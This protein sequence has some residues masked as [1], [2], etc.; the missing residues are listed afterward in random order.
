MLI[1]V[2]HVIMNIV[3]PISLPII[4]MVDEFLG[5]YESS[6]KLIITKDSRSKTP[7]VALSMHEGGRIKSDI[8]MNNINI[9]GYTNK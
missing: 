6:I 7:R 1:T 8:V 5:V 9:N 3:N 2:D 4:E